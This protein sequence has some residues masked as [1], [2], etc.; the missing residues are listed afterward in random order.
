MSNSIKFLDKSVSWFYF[1]GLMIYH[2]QFPDAVGIHTSQTQQSHEIAQNPTCLQTK[3][4]NPLAH[5]RLDILFTYTI[6]QFLPP[7]G[8]DIPT[9]HLYTSTC[10]RNPM[11][12]CDSAICFDQHCS[13]LPPPPQLYRRPQP[14]THSSMINPN[15]IPLS[16]SPIGIPNPIPCT[17][18]L[19]IVDNVNHFT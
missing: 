16:Q 4:D 14:S 13:T 6:L 11:L 15:P 12:P 2:K 8:Y 5:S 9:K 17:Q 1:L 19:F 18:F 7:T 10:H 3:D